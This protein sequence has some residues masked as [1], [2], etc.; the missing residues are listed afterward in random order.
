M[1]TCRLRQD[2]PQGHRALAAAAR[3]PGVALG[4][5]GE[6]CGQP[7][8]RLDDAGIPKQARQDAA[9]P[10]LQR[11]QRRRG[12]RRRCVP[13]AVP[14]AD[15][16][17]AAAA[18]AAAAEGWA[19]PT[20]HQHV[21]QEH[22][23]WRGQL[24][25]ADGRLGLT[26]PPRVGLPLCVEAHHLPVRRGRGKPA[27]LCAA[28][29]ARRHISGVGS[30]RAAVAIAKQGSLQLQQASLRV[31]Q[32][33]PVRHCRW[34]LVKGGCGP[35][36]CRGHHRRYAACCLWRC[37][38]RWR[39]LNELHRMHHNITD[40]RPALQMAGAY[41]SNAGRQASAHVL[42]LQGRH[43]RAAARTARAHLGCTEASALCM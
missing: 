13:S 25:Q 40:Q 23:L 10:L 33:E 38:S 6:V 39:G 41:S 21:Q 19:L 29:A 1:H 9:E 17:T 26:Q 27:R 22:G 42:P 5:A 12:S 30:L 36:C 3:Q 43:Y 24:Q 20:Q 32:H 11:R 34:K 28:W 7:E 16:S 31:H 4:Q 14:S 35:C 8:S 15:A 37:G 18:A 2:A